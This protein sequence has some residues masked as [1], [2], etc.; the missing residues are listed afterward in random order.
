MTGDI[1]VAGDG[2][3]VLS[4]G[5][6]LLDL[7]SGEVTL[8]ELERPDDAEL[9]ELLARPTGMAVVDKGAHL[10]VALPGWGRVALMDLNP[11]SDTYGATLK[12]HAVP[13]NP[14]WVIAANLAD[15][16]VYLLDDDTGAVVTLNSQGQ[17]TKEITLR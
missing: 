5:I 15:D 14:R 6:A 3:I 17:V 12:T 7:T 1:D 13:G 4:E 9:D 10:V 16:W 11:E 8:H 2:E